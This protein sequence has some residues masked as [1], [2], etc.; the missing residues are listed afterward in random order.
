MNR[1]L[2]IR[3]KLF[4]MM[5]GVLVTTVAGSSLMLIRT[6]EAAARTDLAAVRVSLKAQ[7]YERA[8]GLAVSTRSFVEQL[9]A[10]HQLDLIETELRA[11]RQGQQGL[12]Y[13]ILQDDNQRA[14]VHPDKDQVATILSDDRAVWARSLLN[15]SS[16]EY[17]GER[18][19]MVEVAVPVRE[20]RLDEETGLDIREPVAALRLGFSMADL[21]VAIAEAEARHRGDVRRA[22]KI[23]GALSGG[24][25]L[26]GLILAF[27]FG[28]RLTTPIERLTGDAELI[29]EGNFDRVI[30]V[31]DANADDEIGR[32]GAAFEK[33][34]LSIQDLMLRT[35]ERARMETE[36][37]TAHEV[38]TAM[39]PRSDPST[40]RFDV[41]AF[42][43]PATE[44]GG[45]WY[46]YIREG[47]AL[48]VVVGDV[49]GHGAA[50]A[51]VATAARSATS[52]LARSAPRG[53]GPKRLL[54][55]LN[56]ELMTI[57]D[58]E[59]SHRMTCAVVRIDLTSGGLTFAGAAHTK[60]L[61]IR[62]TGQTAV[63]D[64]RGPILGDAS[65]VCFTEHT[66]R[67]APGDTLLL[68]TDGLIENENREGKEWGR[69]RL[70]KAFR[71]AVRKGRARAVVDEIQDLAFAFYDGRT[72]AD[73]VT[74]VAVRHRPPSSGPTIV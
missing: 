17:E 12:R 33:M 27:V 41:A 15:L 24:A 14:M 42:Y 31:K 65:D 66:D 44:M 68:Y 47:A 5:A 30:L 6:Q 28:T 45:D 1:S 37:H 43:L 35:A 63:L 73:D 64:S 57:G 56:E 9:M 21:E 50:S 39:L 60:P 2:S 54:E 7:L 67:L 71:G 18:G 38:Q 20:L 36:L 25:L 16:M 40:D 29:A 26:V 52:V 55:I 4:L 11:L 69:R 19:R 32:L 74:F 48:Y 53:F 34:R 51:L 49:T 10:E 59:H 13:T 8:G 58:R 61:V 70:L 3:S 23:A 62:A 46:A 22:W 72:I